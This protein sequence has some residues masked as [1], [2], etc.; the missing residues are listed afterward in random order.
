MTNFFFCLEEKVEEKT[1]HK[2]KRD[3]R[4]KIGIQK[5]KKKDSKHMKRSYSIKRKSDETARGLALS[6]SGQRL[7]LICSKAGFALTQRIFTHVSPNCLHTYKL[8]IRMYPDER[9]DALSSKE[10]TRQRTD[11]AGAT[12]STRGAAQPAGAQHRHP[13]R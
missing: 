7:V 6:R 12:H 4:K 5:K 9:K 1:Y 3:V 11:A 2:G 13:Q 10:R 8:T